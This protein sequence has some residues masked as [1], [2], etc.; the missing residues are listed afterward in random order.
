MPPPRLA[1]RLRAV[2]RARPPVPAGGAL[3]DIR[4]AMAP[5]QPLKLPPDPHLAGDEV[6]ER[7]AQA[8]R[9]PLAQPA[10]EADRPPRAV[11]PLGDR[12]E[13]GAGLRLGQCL[14]P[15]LAQPGRLDQLARIAGDI[16]APHLDL[17]GAR[18]D[19][20]DLPDRP[21]REVTGEHLRIAVLQVLGQHPVDPLGAP[22]REDLVLAQRP[23]A[24][25]GPGRAP[26]LRQHHVQMPREH[27]TDRPRPAGLDDLS[28]VPL[29]LQ[30]AHGLVPCR[31]RLPLNMPAVQRA[32]RP[33]AHRDLGLVIALGVWL[34]REVRLA[35]AAP[36]A[37]H[38]PG[39]HSA[40]FSRCA[41]R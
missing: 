18:Q 8:E 20:V 25:D 3:R 41:S 38:C 19:R 37:G 2:P 39:S 12:D 30:L 33:G 23:V 28:G 15:G 24:G 40:S 16:A 7:P 31:L 1:G 26:A 14:L 29:A 36:G 34:V 21:G 10:G 27:L 9:L 5:R 22:P 13:H 17:V 35:V 6:D 4:A 32:V 11:S